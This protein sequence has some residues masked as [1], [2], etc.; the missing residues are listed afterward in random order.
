V[1]QR[2]CQFSIRNI[3]DRLENI[4]FPVISFITTTGFSKGQANPA[5]DATLEPM[6]LIECRLRHFARVVDIPDR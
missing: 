4:R 5:G 2:K 6:S 1:L 3:A